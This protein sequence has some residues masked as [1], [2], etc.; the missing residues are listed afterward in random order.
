MLRK[1]LLL[2]LFLIILISES[3]GQKYKKWNVEVRKYNPEFYYTDEAQRIGDNLLLYQHITGGWP[4]NIYFPE[5]LTE[6]QKRVV[7]SK[8]SD[9][10]E[11]TIDNSATTVEIKYLANLYNATKKDQ[12]KKAVIDGV[13][14]LLKAQYENGGWPQFYPR[15]IGY[16]TQITFNDNA[17]VN[18]M[19]QLREIF[20]NKNPYLF[21]D[22][23][24]KDRAKKAFDKGIECILNCQVRQNG[25][26]T[27][28]CAQH[29]KKSLLPCK[30]R[31]Y[32]LPSLSGAESA[33]IVLLLMS[34]KNPSERIRQSIEGAVRWFENSKIENLNREEYINSDGKK[35]Y[36]MVKVKNSNAIWARFYELD[37][38]RP[39]FSD[40]DGVIMYD[41]SEIGYER[42]NGYS[43]YNSSGI[44]VLEMYK[45]WLEL[46]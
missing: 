21:L 23:S 35:D 34:I 4:K 7:I 20:E 44:R 8:K 1:I 41:I 14:Y 12:Y 25:M 37:T 18:V 43:W 13:E 19:L 9:V 28:W 17:M 24:L 27:V 15:P 45:R 5:I 26:L 36:R 22:D 39:I 40:R 42:R 16:Y 33:E 32:E 2:S 11:S 3:V 10:N 6:E 31:A 46:N 38:N 30:A 29:D